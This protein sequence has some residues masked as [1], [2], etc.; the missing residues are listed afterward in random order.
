MARAAKEHVKE[1]RESNF[2]RIQADTDTLRANCST[3]YILT[4]S[5]GKAALQSEFHHIICI[6]S[7]QDEHIKPKNKLDFFHNCMALTEWDINDG[8]NLISLPTKYVYI[9]SEWYFKPFQLLV[10]IHYTTSGYA[11]QLAQSSAFGTLPDLPCHKVEHETFRL[12]IIDY[13]IENLWEP[14]EDEQ[15]DCNIEG[16]SIQGELESTSLQW[17]MFLVE[18]G[19]EVKGTAYC[20]VNRNNPELENKWYIPFSMNPGTPAKCLPPPAPPKSG[21][22]SAVQA[23][24]SSL[25]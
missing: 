16:R 18:R 7:I 22:K 14:L 4:T 8:S 23:W 10:Q 12:K 1:I 9:N 17:R 3:G 11:S 21:D 2:N 13:L 19:R 25:F 24:L 15:E 6:Q 5:A 20:W